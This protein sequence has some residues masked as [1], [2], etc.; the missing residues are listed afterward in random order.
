MDSSGNETPSYKI[1]SCPEYEF[2]GMLPVT[3]KKIQKLFGLEGSLSAIK[4]KVDNGTI[5]RLAKRYGYELIIFNDDDSDTTS[6][7][8]MY[9][10]EVWVGGK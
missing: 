8:E 7:A 3:L 6:Y 9:L 4:K 1:K 2:D 10:K 5:A